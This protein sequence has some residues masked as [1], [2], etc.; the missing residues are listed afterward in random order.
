MDKDADATFRD[1]LF[2]EYITHCPIDDYAPA[3]AVQTHRYKLVHHLLAGQISYPPDG[4]H[5]EGCPDVWAALKSPQGT[6]AR[7]TYDE[8]VNPPEFQLYDRQSDPDEHNNLANNPEYAE[9]LERLKKELMQWRKETNDP[10]LN[11]TYTAAFTKHV[12]EHQ[13]T[14][15]QWEKDNP[16]K[17]VWSSPVMRPDMKSFIQ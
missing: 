13:K 5:A 17:N 3:R 9:V 7:K 14:V 2:T 8:F 15:E 1:R 16:N 12:T 11:E 4:V 6:V 10:F